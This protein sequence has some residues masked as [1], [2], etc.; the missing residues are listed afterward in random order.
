MPRVTVDLEEPIFKVF[1][2]KCIDLGK[3]K[4]EVLR[5]LISK[6]LDDS[7]QDRSGVSDD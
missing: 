5:D 4:T 2:K 6:F 1:S 3:R 7:A